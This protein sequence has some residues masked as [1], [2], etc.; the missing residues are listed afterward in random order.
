MKYLLGMLYPVGPADESSHYK[1]HGRKL[2]VEEASINSSWLT[3]RLYVSHVIDKVLLSPMS[4]SLRVIME[5]DL[6]SCGAGV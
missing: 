5:L 4:L 2:L 1:H 3:D 6:K